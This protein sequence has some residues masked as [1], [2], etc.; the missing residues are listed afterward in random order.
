MGRPVRS[1]ESCDKEKV[2]VPASTAHL[3]PR[4]RRKLARRASEVPL[5][6]PVKKMTGL[7]SLEPRISTNFRPTRER[8]QNPFGSPTPNPAD[9][10][11]APTQLCISHRIDRAWARRGLGQIISRVATHSD[12]LWCS[13]CTQCR[14]APGL[15]QRGART[16]PVTF[17]S[18]PT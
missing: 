9:C 18:A 10:I 4:G 3:T 16:S 15:A 1:R 12:G 7:L 13:S 5:Q 11:V 8:G 6:T 14:T 2:E 17:C